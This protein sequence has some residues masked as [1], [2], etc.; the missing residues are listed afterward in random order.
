[1]GFS[2]G[3]AGAVALT[4][5]LGNAVARQ[6]YMPNAKHA[7]FKFSLVYSGF[8]FKYDIYNDVYATK[9]DTPLLHVVG[10]L[11]T[12]TGKDRTDT[13][14][15]VVEKGVFKQI[16]HPGG[17]HVPQQ[18]IWVKEVIQFVQEAL[19]RDQ[20]ALVKDQEASEK[21]QEASEEDN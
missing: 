12:V 13:V 2:Q 8:K 16:E 10:T 21:D 17:H 15:S 4:A 18:K 9:I 6:K 7:P 20:E 5:I 11:D 19:Q 14:Q 3:A 1:M